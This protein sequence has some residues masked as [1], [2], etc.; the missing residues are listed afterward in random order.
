[1]HKCGT[2]CHNINGVSAKF[3]PKILKLLKKRELLC[4]V[5]GGT[6]AVYWKEKW[7]LYLLINMYQPIASGHC[8]DKDSVT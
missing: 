3:W 6:S 2:I 1:M 4:K 7:K 5:K 8:V